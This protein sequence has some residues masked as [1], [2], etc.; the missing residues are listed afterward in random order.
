MRS[1]G[2]KP[3]RL[4]NSLA[5]FLAA[6]KGNFYAERIEDGQP[7]EM[8]RSNKTESY[9]LESCDTKK[10]MKTSLIGFVGRFISFAD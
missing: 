7:D 6:E 8:S 2:K 10:M 5:D 4:N 9:S 3:I 1:R